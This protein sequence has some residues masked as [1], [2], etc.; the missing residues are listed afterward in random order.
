MEV[1]APAGRR[2][3]GTAGQG[4]RQGERRHADR[5]CSTQRRPRR[6]PR[7]AAGEQPPPAAARRG[8][9]ARGAG[10]RAAPARRAATYA[11]KADVECEMLVLGAG[12]GGYSAAFRAADLG[13]KT[14]L[15]ERYADA[16]RRL[17]QR[18][19]HSVQ[20]A[21]ARRRGDR[22]GDAR[23]PSTASRSARRRS[24]STSCARWKDKV[25]GKLTGGLA[26]MAKVRKVD[27]RARLRP[28]PRPEP[29][30]GRADRGRTGK[31]GAKKVVK[32]AK[33]IIAAGSQAVQLPF[34]PEDPRIVDSTG[35]LELRDDP[36]AACW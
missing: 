16:R 7:R 15:V 36:E 10:G 5:S 35:A 27:G 11:G 2:R 34:M 14:V 12:P 13:L 26:G 22:R 19:L 23:W 6:Q 21:A 20:G 9:A 30:R 1:P 28:V 33:A 8:R 17:P 4:R 29:H 24:T 31:T 32:F 25:V 3:Q 18:R